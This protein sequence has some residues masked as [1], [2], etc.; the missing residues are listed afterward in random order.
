MSFSSSEWHA[1]CDSSLRVAVWMWRSVVAKS[2]AAVLAVGGVPSSAMRGMG[3]VAVVAA[4]VDDRGCGAAAL[5]VVDEQISRE[6]GIRHSDCAS[7]SRT[8]PTG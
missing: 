5:L 7:H 8:A 2:T 6:P 4:G 3:V 1:A